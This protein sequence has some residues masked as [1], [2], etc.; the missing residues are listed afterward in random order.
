[1]RE[2]LRSSFCFSL[3]F[4]KGNTRH[5]CSNCIYVVF[6]SCLS[7]LC[8]VCGNKKAV[9]GLWFSGTAGGGVGRWDYWRGCS[10]GKFSSSSSIRNVTSFSAFRISFSCPF[11]RVSL[12]SNCDTRSSTSWTLA[13]SS[14]RS[15][16]VNLL[17]IVCNV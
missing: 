9:P 4:C 16:I 17:H 8:R 2:R 14:T 12:T 6:V 13:F 10:V 5:C 15:I 7:C 1:M 3:L 11:K